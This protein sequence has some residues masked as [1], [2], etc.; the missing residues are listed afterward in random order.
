M[1]YVYSTLSCDNEYRSYVKGGG[2]ID[3]VES[4]VLIKGGAGVMNKNI[5][6]P[7]G[8][9]T[10]VTKEQLEMLERNDQF[11]LHKTNGFITVDSKKIDADEAAKN[12]AKKDKSAPATMDDYKGANKPIV[13]KE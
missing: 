8:I 4:H 3:Q 5:I 2:D 6:T 13:N 11:Q 7:Y 9:A 12:M 10:E 1:P